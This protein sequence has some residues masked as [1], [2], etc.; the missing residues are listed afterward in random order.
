M[1]PTLAPGSGRARGW[2]AGTRA[3]LGRAWRRLGPASAL[4]I[5]QRLWS[6]IFPASCHL[7]GLKSGDE[8]D[9]CPICCRS[10]PLN[11]PA[12]ARCGNALT[13]LENDWGSH[14]RA[15]A[16]L[17]GRCLHRPPPFVSAL[18]PY[19][20]SAPSDFLVQSLKY[21]GQLALADVLGKLLAR[22]AR[23]RPRETGIDCLLAVPLADRRLRG[24][25]F[26]QAREIAIV[27]AKELAIPL[28]PPTACTRVR[29]AST[30]Q[31]AKTAAQRRRL[32]SRDFFAD[33][34][35]VRG[36]RIALVDD[37]ATTRA[38]ASAV[39]RALLRGGAAEVSFWAFAGAAR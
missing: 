31:M 3:G 22:A 20:Y 7:C 36:L 35:A 24:R 25:G 21:R 5:K 16:P 33:P 26:N 8:I 12:C 29:S 1:R 2:I 10:L 19:L 18:I 4:L 14:S 6:A 38:T 37:V 34:E 27:V 28:A 9:L 39:T 30:P 32:S 13:E 11:N 15:A 23:S 17:C